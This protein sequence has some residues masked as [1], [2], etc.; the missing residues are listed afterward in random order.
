MRDGTMK[1]FFMR[2]TPSMRITAVDISKLRDNDMK[3]LREGE[4]ID[5]EEQC[6]SYKWLYEKDIVQVLPLTK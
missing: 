5:H 2:Y 6:Y 3:C 4:L 1:K